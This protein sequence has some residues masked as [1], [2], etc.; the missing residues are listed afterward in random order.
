MLP[1]STLHPLIL[2]YQKDNRVDT[3]AQNESSSALRSCSLMATV[4]E[5]KGLLVDDIHKVHTVIPDNQNH[6]IGFNP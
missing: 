4:K 5:N 6:D 3:N 2:L 1:I